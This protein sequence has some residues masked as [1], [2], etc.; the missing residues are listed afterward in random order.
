MAQEEKSRQLVDRRLR[1]RQV[2]RYTEDL[3][4]TDEKHPS[5]AILRNECN[6]GYVLL[7][8]LG[9]QDGIPEGEGE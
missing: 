6:P 8:H 5:L 3:R 9:W 1:A 2:W 7:E 4:S